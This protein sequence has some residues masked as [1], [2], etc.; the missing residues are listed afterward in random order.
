MLRTIADFRRCVRTPWDLFIIGT[1]FCIISISG[2]LSEFQPVLQIYHID[3]VE[4]GREL[5]I[6]NRIIC[7]G[8]GFLICNGLRMKEHWSNC[9]EW[10]NKT[11]IVWGVPLTKSSNIKNLRL[12]LFILHKFLKTCLDGNYIDETFNKAE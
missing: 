4:Q 1:G 6:S 11:K 3:D 5:C 8:Q 12:C 10:L 9:R 7:Y 2:S